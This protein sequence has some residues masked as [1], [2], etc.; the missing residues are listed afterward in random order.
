MK[1]RHEGTAHGEARVGQVTDDPV[2]S[3]SNS[4]YWDRKLA[5]SLEH[6]GLPELPNH[7]TSPYV[8]V[9]AQR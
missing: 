4:D 8:A 7:W 5:W 1:R 6:A 9:V 2:D 3:L